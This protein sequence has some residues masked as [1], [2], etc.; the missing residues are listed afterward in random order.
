V[1]LFIN[2][3][4]LTQQMSGVQRYAREL[5]GALDRRLG[6]DPGLRAAL[7]PVLALHPLGAIDDPDWTQIKV[8]GLGGGSGHMWEQGAL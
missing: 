6:D 2:A 7:G 1:S 5:L 8:Q 3:R 4:F